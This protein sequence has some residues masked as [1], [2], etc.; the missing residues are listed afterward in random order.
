MEINNRNSMAIIQAGKNN[1]LYVI[2]QFVLFRFLPNMKYLKL[3]MAK[4]GMCPKHN[5]QQVTDP[6]K[7]LDPV[8]HQ[9]RRN[10]PV[11]VFVCF[12]FV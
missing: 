11:C 5:S 12:Y 4:I 10:V 7:E 2:D 1:I 3:G 8:N 6:E 9:A